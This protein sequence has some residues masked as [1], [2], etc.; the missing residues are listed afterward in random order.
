M[1]GYYVYRFDVIKKNNG[2]IDKVNVEKI[3][4]G[5]S[6]IEDCESVLNTVAW[7]FDDEDNAYLVIEFEDNE[8]IRIAGVYYVDDGEGSMDV[9]G[10]DF[11][12][13]AS[14]AFGTDWV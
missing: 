7:Y 14:I 2:H 4:G 11:R 13:I 6:C 3:L 9:A 5:F 8:P 1:E 12:V 10:R